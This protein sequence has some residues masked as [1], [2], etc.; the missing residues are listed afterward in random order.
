[1]AHDP[2]VGRF[3]QDALGCRARAPLVLELEVELLNDGVHL[4]E[5]LV[6]QQLVGLA[7]GP[8]ALRCAQVPDLEFRVE[9]LSLER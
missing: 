6:W 4:D 1:M 9:V 8:M 3:G 7:L 5:H 2:V